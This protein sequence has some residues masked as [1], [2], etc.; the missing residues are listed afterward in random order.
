M[1][2]INE[3]MNSSG[4]ACCVKPWLNGLASQRT[5]SA[6][7][8]LAFRLATHGFANLR[9]LASPFGQP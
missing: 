5:F 7:V 3:Y 9:R 1:E 8:Q 2:V 6:C 4:R